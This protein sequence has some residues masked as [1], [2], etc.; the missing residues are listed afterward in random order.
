MGLRCLVSKG[1]VQYI[2]SQNID[3][4]HLK[5]GLERRY[6]SE[7]HGNMFIEQCNKCR[8]QF[9][10]TTATTTVGQK[11]C[12]G[13]CRRSC[14]GGILMDNILDWEHDLPE[15]DLD[16][17]FMHSRYA[18]RVVLYAITIIKGILYHIYKLVYYPPWGTQILTHFL[19]F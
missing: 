18:F 13:T 4:L 10:R 7:L 8:R 6:L 17:A 3:G 14:R 12:G 11:P 15:K 9:I 2:V 5:S 16:L 19:F 1:Y